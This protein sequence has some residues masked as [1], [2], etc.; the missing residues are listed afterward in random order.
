M[1]RTTHSRPH[2]GDR[3]VHDRRAQGESFSDSWI[4]CCQSRGTVRRFTTAQPIGAHGSVEKRVGEVFPCFGV[5]RGNAQPV[6]RPARGWGNPSRVWRHEQGRSYFQPIPA[7]S[8]SFC[9]GNVR[10]LR[11][12]AQ[13]NRSLIGQEEWGRG[14]R[15]RFRRRGAPAGEMFAGCWSRWGNRSPIGREE[16]FTGGESFAHST[17]EQGN[18]SREIGEMFSGSRWGRGNRLQITPRPSLARGNVR[19]DTPFFGGS[20]PELS[21]RCLNK[22]FLTNDLRYYAP[23]LSFFLTL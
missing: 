16:T 3:G 20:V 17:P 23:A 1:H 2:R 9:R 10:Q 11:R 6:I 13:G 4:A 5:Y 15:E 18:H 19:A 22:I 21:A 7:E 8:S 14:M 12:I